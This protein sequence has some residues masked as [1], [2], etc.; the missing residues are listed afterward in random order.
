MNIPCNPM[1]AGENHKN[2]CV[3]PKLLLVN[4][5]VDGVYHP[6]IAVDR[7]DAQP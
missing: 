7:T 6:I 1:A 2:E 4:N 5:V 3:Q